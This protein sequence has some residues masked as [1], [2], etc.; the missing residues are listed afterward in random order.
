VAVVDQG[1]DEEA[2]YDVDPPDN[3]PIPSPAFPLSPGN[4]G[5]WESSGIVD[6][7]S[8]F[9][10]GAFLINVQAHTLWID[11][12]AGTGF[13]YKREGGQLLL[14]TVPGA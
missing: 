1:L 5:A 11:S 7:S 4:L 9:G 14:L 6:V 13:T 2:G 8:V 10:E 12:D 3:P